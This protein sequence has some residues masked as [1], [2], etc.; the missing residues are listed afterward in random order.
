MRAQTLTPENLRKQFVSRAI[1]N[2]KRG[3][4]DDESGRG[5]FRSEIRLDLQRS[6]LMTE[7][8]KATEGEAMVLRRAKALANILNKM[9]I[10]IRDYE[11]IV[12]YQTAE[13]NGIFHPIEQ[14][15]KSPQRLANSPAG[16]TLLDDAGRKEL[17]E[18]CK[19]WKG[20]SI[21]DRHQAVLPEDLKKYWTYEGTFLWSQLSELGIPN[22][23][24]LFNL[25]LQGLINEIREKMARLDQKIPADYVEQKDFLTASII[26]LEA[27]INF[28]KRYAVLAKE[29]AVRQKNATRKKILE[30]IAETCAWVPANPPRTFIEAIQFFYFIHLVRYLEYSTLGIGVRIDYLFGPYYEKDLKEGKIT[31]EETLGILQLLWIKLNELGLV[32]SPTVSSVYSGVASLQAVTIGGTDEKGRDVTNDL[33]YLTMEAAK[34]L[35]I[36]EPS[37][38]LRVHEGTPDE[39]YSR[40]TDV[41][42]TGIGYPSLFNDEALIPLYERWGVP[43]N[44]AKQYAVSGC[45]Y[46]EIPGK[47]VVRRSVGY[48]VLPKCLWWALHQGVNPK[49]GE[50]H[51]AKTPDPAT[52]KSWEDVLEAYAEQVK[53]FTSKIET[54]ERI[55]NELLTQYAPRPFYSALLDGCIEQGKDCRRWVYNSL[56]HHFSQVIGGTNVADAITA[57]KKIVF[58]DRKVTLPE[59]ITI[60]DK[61]WAG[62]EDVRLACLNAP[63]FGN[64]DDYADEIARIVQTRGEAAMEEVTDRFGHSHRGDGSAVSATYGLAADTPATPD[65]RFDREP[66][67]DSTL[68]PAPGRDKKGPT[69]VLK[70]CSKI[71]TVNTFNHLLNQKFLPK[72]LEDDL[73]PAFLSY[74]KTWKKLKVPHIQ[75][76][77]VDRETLLKAKAQPERYSDLIVR[78]AGFSAYFVDLSSGLQDHIIARTEQTLT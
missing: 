21:S 26:S 54:L 67:A 20:K 12:G 55:N 45:V 77:V 1:R 50:Q 70:S 62:R 19:Y 72:F 28:A 17:D 61:N 78:V 4:A 68:A 36:I 33:T 73:K 46:I 71:S 18:L 69:A 57:I 24:K 34:S 15:W 13:P 11:R 7:S 29:S 3:Y 32:Y 14:N 41:I 58:E 16:K 31:K 2:I 51:G 42:K 23:E 76:N 6:R 52:F 48:F 39:V 8:Y 49:T 66:F 9:G 63:K 53:F 30:E 40:A 38:A 25:G 27:V 56:L 5:M 60:M 59:L 65:G 74:L 37:I 64:D 43:K 35:K 47:N 44:E 75:F 22:Y 10:F